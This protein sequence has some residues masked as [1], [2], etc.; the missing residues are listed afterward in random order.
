MSRRLRSKLF[1]HRLTLAGAAILLVGAV[2]GGVS[3]ER[4]R[5][6]LVNGFVRNTEQVAAAFDRTELDQLSAT[7][8]DLTSPVYGAVKARL[9]RCRGAQPDLRMVRLLR[10]EAAT[11]RVFLLAD[12]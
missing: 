8:A 4:T 5:R 3:G 1:K 6:D 10:V 9:I 7:P 12:S 2:A 11:R